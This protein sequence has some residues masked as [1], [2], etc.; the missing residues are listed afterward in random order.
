MNKPRMRLFIA[1][2]D[3]N[4]DVLLCSDGDLLL[5]SDDR[6]LVDTRGIAEV[7]IPVE[8]WIVVDVAGND[9]IT[10]LTFVNVQS[11]A[12]MGRAKRVAIMGVRRYMVWDEVRLMAV[13]LGKLVTAPRLR[14]I[15]VHSFFEYFHTIP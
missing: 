6:G 4:N 3:F 1:A 8:F 12:R 15:Y 5:F 13:S 9:D 10:R 14:Y 11:F 2:I 7:G